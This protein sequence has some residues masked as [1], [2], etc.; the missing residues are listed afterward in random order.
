MIGTTF[1]SILLTTVSAT[2]PHVFKKD[3]IP[4]CSCLV[5]IT[6]F[7]LFI[8][9]PL[10]ID[11]NADYPPI[12]VTTSTR[13]DRVHP[14]HARKFVKVSEYPFFVWLLRQKINPLTLLMY[15]IQNDLRNCGMLA[16][17]NGLSTT[18]RT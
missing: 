3:F 18:M 8:A 5:S 4:A 9:F 17:A 6:N 7:D 10:D 16:K 14:G 1:R 12:L 15:V 11:E 13:D 2:S